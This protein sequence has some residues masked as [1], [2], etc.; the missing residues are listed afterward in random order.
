MTLL[1]DTDGYKII[2]II[3]T[4]RMI[5][6]LEAWMEQQLVSSG[7]KSNEIINAMPEVTKKEVSSVDT[8]SFIY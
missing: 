4:K 5:Q 6:E 8:N 1:N 2:N 7:E 3:K